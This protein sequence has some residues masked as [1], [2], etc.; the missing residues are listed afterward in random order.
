MTAESKTIEVGPMGAWATARQ[1]ANK[2]EDEFGITINVVSKSQLK[3]LGYTGEAALMFEGVVVGGDSPMATLGDVSLYRE[4][5][6]DRYWAE[7]YSGW[8]VTLWKRE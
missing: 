6:S 4:L 7:A 5:S 8:M 1:W 2:I 3:E